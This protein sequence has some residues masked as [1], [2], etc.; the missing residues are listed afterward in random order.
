MISV[1]SKAEVLQS[2]DFVKSSEHPRIYDQEELKAQQAAQVIE[3]MIETRQKRQLSSS[4][5]KLIKETQSS[6]ENQRQSREIESSQQEVIS[7]DDYVE[8]LKHTF[9][10]LDSNTITV[11]EA[12]SE[13]FVCCKKYEQERPDQQKILQFAEK[14]KEIRA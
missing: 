11:S 9:F 7:L 2:I 5:E 3:R 8:G 6:K 4:I 14:N 12:L 13:L 1:D 10:R